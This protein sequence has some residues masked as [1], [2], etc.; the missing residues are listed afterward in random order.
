MSKKQACPISPVGNRVVV[1][2]EEASESKTK[3]GI[4]I[5]GF[6]QDGYKRGEVL[7]VGPG[8][9][10][11]GILVP[12]TLKVGDKVVLGA[13]GYDEVKVGDEVYYVVIE[14]SILA[15]LNN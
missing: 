5:P 8:T 6:S 10:Q 4:V 15:K 9:Y 7:A 2:V 12:M 11:D 13:H 3:Q 1:R 14:S